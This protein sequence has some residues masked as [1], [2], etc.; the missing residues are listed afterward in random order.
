MVRKTKL[1]LLGLVVLLI[2]VVVLLPVFLSLPQVQRAAVNK[3]NEKMPGHLLVDGCRFGWK[4]P[5]VCKQIVF[6]DADRGLHVEIPRLERNQGLFSLFV[7]PMNMGTIDVFDPL[8]VLAA[9]SPAS[10]EAALSKSEQTSP[11]STPSSGVPV[12][13]VAHQKS[14]VAWEHLMGRLNIH[15]AIVR[16][17][18]ADRITQVLMQAGNL[19]ARLN[20][21][22]VH[23][24]VD[25]TAGDKESGS[26]EASGFINLPTSQHGFMD[27][28]VTEINLHVM[29][30]QVAPFLS[31]FSE[32]TNIPT[33]E[34]RLSSELLIKTA[35]INNLTIKGT[36]LLQQLALAGGI[37]GEDR[38]FFKQIN[39]DVDARRQGS[40]I[41]N[42]SGLH[43]SSDVATVA[44]DGKARSGAVTANAR[45]HL[46][47]PALFGQLPHLFKVQQ[48]T[49]VQ[50]GSLDFTLDTTRQQHHLDVKADLKTH[51][52]SGKSNGRVFSWKNPLQCKVVASFDKEGPLIKTLQ[53]NAP[54]FNLDGQGSLK[55][56]SLQGTADLD[57]AMKELGT[58]FVLDWSTGGKLRLSSKSS[59]IGHKRYKVDAQ[60]NISQFTLS[61]GGKRVL[62]RH[63]FSFIGQ[64]ETPTRFPVSLQDAMQGNFH[65]NA[66][67]GTMQGIFTDLFRA[68]DQLTTQYQIRSK[69]NM[70]RLMD[71]AHNMALVPE[72]TMTGQMNVELA[73]STEN[74]IF[75]LRQL[76]ATCRDFIFYH[77]GKRFRDP[78]VRI[79]LV[80][81]GKQGI[82]GLHPLEIAPSL[83]GY[84]AKGG[85]A[86]LVDLANH[87]LRLVGMDISTSK[88]QLA[89]HR[90]SVEDWQQPVVSLSLDVDGKGD[91]DK[92]T[93]LLQQF[94]VLKEKQSVA[95]RST[96]R[97]QLKKQSKETKTGSLHFAISDWDVNMDG[98]QLFSDQQMS[99]DT[100]IKFN[101]TTSKMVFDSFDVDLPPGGIKAVGK[102]QTMNN[103]SD[104]MLK[105]QLQLD[106]AQLSSLVN[107]LKPMGIDARGSTKEDFSLQ[108]PLASK[109]GFSKMTFATAV[110]VSH[111]GAFGV[112]LQD[113]AMPVHMDKGILQTPLTAKLYGGA[114][115]IA[116]TV[117]F[118]AKTP[119]ITLPAGQQLLSDVQ[120]EKPLVHILQRITPLLGLL[121]SPQG[122]VSARADNF[123]WPLGKNGAEQAVF[124]MVFDLSKITFIA[125]GLMSEIMQIA[126]LG[127]E[128]LSLAQSEVTCKA[129][130]GR[131]TCTPL[132]I[133]VAGS[134]MSLAGSMGFDGTIDYQL[135]VPVTSQLVGKEGYRVLEG[136]T[137]TVP[138]KGNQQHAFFDKEALTGAVSDLLGQAAQKAGQK[139][140][141]KQVDKLFHG[142]S[143]KILGK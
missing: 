128:P 26:V 126:G 31:L 63:D 104:L 20:D 21:G 78:A 61:R 8:V 18:V 3:I 118:A 64:L 17:K 90:L 38:P 55:T 116:P 48:G 30:L 112:E 109:G 28:L 89:I 82:N 111:F 113:I 96:F 25:F 103:A 65:I 1:V 12:N 92:L 76:D 15:H 81:S 5:L 80:P 129:A 141:E 74:K 11:T 57:Q 49:V 22:T 140:F 72:T 99:V 50:H 27:T 6:D 114:L 10:Q 23:F 45:G 127:S 131:I 70:G 44:I 71:M 13:T 95:G 73:G 2:A 119:L 75:A 102:L 122:K 4:E 142:L 125:D 77:K 110:N 138:I 67:P 123:S 53:L 94:G 47:I 98:K 14:I 54:F 115:Q 88:V 133:M 93:P 134:A 33:G 106:F 124:S 86:S 42:F 91:L 130:Q 108:Y 51:G 34:G 39:L 56:F 97:A 105:G 60:V 7:A 43:L 29:D 85:N 100:D 84:S 59:Q 83:A 135:E 137:I 41:W 46:D 139:F 121:T 32:S 35:G 36:A 68:N 87:V 62:P 79:Q 58:L 40:N 69:V 107:T 143:D 132:K 24:T 9:P 52:I 117:D 66:W 120:L 136:T 37:L 19:T 101:T 16:Q